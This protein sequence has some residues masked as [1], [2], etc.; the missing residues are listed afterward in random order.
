MGIN[1]T[2]E[3]AATQPTIKPTVDAITRVVPEILS[4]TPQTRQANP[5]EYRTTTSRGIRAEH[6]GQLRFA[7][8]SLTYLEKSD[9]TASA[10]R[11]PLTIAP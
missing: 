10:A 11:R 3:T 5:L 9:S 2:L 8:A 7:I 6:I 1:L 4:G